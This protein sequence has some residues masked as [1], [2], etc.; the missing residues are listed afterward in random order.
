MIVWAAGDVSSE[1][2]HHSIQL[3][4]ALTANLRIR[5]G[6]GEPWHLCDAALVRADAPHE[7]DARGATV[8]IAFV[9]PESPLGSALAARI[10][11]DI[12]DVPAAEAARWRNAVCLAGSPSNA[13]IAKWLEVDL[14]G[15]CR[16]QST[17]HPGVRRVLRHVRSH[18]QEPSALSLL[19][20]AEVADLSPSRLMHAFTASMGIALRPYLLW[21]RLQLACGEL[22]RGASATEAALQAGFADAAHFSRTCRRMLGITPTVIAASKASGQIG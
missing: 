8:L 21:L 22:M 4:L 20:L 18:L 12:A 5:R 19:A 1:H 6:G 16:S 13:G 17:L 2:Q 11:A 14:L 10:A 7:V 3:I 15:G 9:E